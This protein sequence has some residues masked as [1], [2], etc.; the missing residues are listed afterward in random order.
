MKASLKN[1]PLFW[2]VLLSTSIA[3]TVL[4]ALTGWALQTYALRV[5][6]QSLEQEVRTNLQTSETLWAMRAHS[7]SSISRIIS[8]M[9]D[10]RAA[11]MTRDDATIRDNA[12]ELW[13]RVSEE[14][15]IFVVLDPSGRVI[16]SLGGDFTDPVVAGLS[17]TGAMAQFPRQVSGFLRRGR[18]LFYVVLTP[19]YVQSGSEQALINVLLAG[20]EVNAK[21]V[22]TLKELTRGGDFAFL[23]N[24]T[25]IAS[26]LKPARRRVTYRAE[27]P[28]SLQKLRLGG[29]DYIVLGSRLKDMQGAPVGELLVLRS[30]AGARHALDELQ[31]NVGLIWFCAVLAGLAFTSLMARRIIEP[32]KQLDRAA[33]EVARHNYGYRVPVGST[34]ELGRLARTFNEM[35]DSISGARE[36]LIRQERLATIARLSSSIVHDLRNPL[37]AI[38]GG[39]EML[40]DSNLTSDQSKRLTASIYKASQ[41]IQELLQDLVNVSR[42]KGESTEICRLDEVVKSAHEAIGNV[43]DSNGVALS[44]AIPNEIE[45]PLER[46]RMRRVF[47]NLINNA[48]EAMP[49]GGDL[50]ISA[51]VEGD[52]ALIEIDDTGSGISPEVR[53]TL[54]QPFAST[55]KR[56]GLGLGLALS[57]Q[58]VL[59]HGGDLW[60]EEKLT[61]GARFKMRLPL[62]TADR[63]SRRIL[64]TE[65]GA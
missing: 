51:K 27:S 53:S 59:D 54:F 58:T 36:E 18:R 10:V 41:R 29:E 47:V 65:R 44:I 31:R 25:V 9:S 32:V 49:H 1:L 6:E 2:R 45:L 55:G 30:F 40:I 52:D 56:N 23:S 63:T 60:A 22:A 34:D 19:V 35:C 17:L 33:S 13:S 11:F 38:Y 14:D 24:G 46:A 15:A 26:T 39:A 37:A 64:E 20:F 3:L 57:R 8:S 12:Q 62:R 16:S 28:G 7:L 50:Q 61:Q 42:G 48:L 5:S 43:A 21:F 4:F